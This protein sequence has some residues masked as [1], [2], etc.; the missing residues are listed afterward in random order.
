M[1]RRAKEW[2]SSEVGG[3]RARLP[4]AQ[5]CPVVCMQTRASLPQ[6]QKGTNSA[7]LSWLMRCSTRPSQAILPNV[8]SS[9]LRTSVT[10][11]FAVGDK[12]SKSTVLNVQPPGKE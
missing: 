3:R 8:K 12:H 1:D 2:K 4:P 10:S 9:R 7:F 6:N 5:L 11:F